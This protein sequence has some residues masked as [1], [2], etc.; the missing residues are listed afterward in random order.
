MIAVAAGYLG[1]RAWRRITQRASS[2]CPRCPQA[3]RGADL[4]SVRRE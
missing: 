2:V 3:C 1:W 4:Q